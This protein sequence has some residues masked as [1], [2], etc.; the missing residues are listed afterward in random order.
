MTD[1]T[2]GRMT[3]EYFPV[4]FPM[5]YRP[6]LSLHDMQIWTFHWL[7]EVWI[8]LSQVDDALQKRRG[9]CYSWTNRCPEIFTSHRYKVAR[10]FDLETQGKRSKMVR[11]RGLISLEGLAMLSS[12]INTPEAAAISL[13]AFH[14]QL[15]VGSQ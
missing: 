2:S 1:H 9:Y 13:W 4:A 5:I 12:R 8:P 6:H 10:I 15:K 7:G 11:K 14:Q 3:D